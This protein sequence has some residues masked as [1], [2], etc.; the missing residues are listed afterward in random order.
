MAGSIYDFVCEDINN[1]PVKMAAFEGKLMLVVNTASYCGFTPQYQGLENL[2]R[3]FKDKGLVVLGFPSNQFAEEPHDNKKIH[4]FCL[5]N[6][7]VT[8]PMFAKVKVNGPQAEP[9]FSYL[10]KARPGLLGAERIQW[11]FTKFLIDR[12]GNVVA[13]FSPLAFPSYIRKKIEA[14]I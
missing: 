1:V 7:G 12:Q 3:D 5:K 9:L 13:R 8:F 11:N 10:E 6:Y 2:Y 4:D 14:M